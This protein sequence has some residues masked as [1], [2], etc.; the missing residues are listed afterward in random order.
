MPTL[1]FNVWPGN[2]RPGMDF[3]HLSGMTI[4]IIDEKE[5]KILF[6]KTKGEL[7]SV[8]L[9]RILLIFEAL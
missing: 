4:K 2:N 9:K 3:L 7:L 5:K 6:I 8:N 1:F